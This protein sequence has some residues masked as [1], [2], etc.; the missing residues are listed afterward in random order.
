VRISVLELLEWESATVAGLAVLVWVTWFF[1]WLDEDKEELYAA[2]KAAAQ[3]RI[4]RRRHRI[5]HE[6]GLTPR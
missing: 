1:G 2:R 4:A 3:Q 6:R 5:A